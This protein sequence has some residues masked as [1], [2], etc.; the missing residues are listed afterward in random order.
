MKVPKSWR[1]M[2]FL[3]WIKTTE[4]EECMDCCNAVDALAPFAE[5]R[6]G[7]SGRTIDDCCECGGAG[8]LKPK[9]GGFEPLSDLEIADLVDEYH[10]AIERGNAI[11]ER[12]CAENLIPSLRAT[13]ARRH[14]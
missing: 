8:V 10:R 1:P 12:L 13:G 6:D 2:T 7:Y 14:I 5:R 11:F 3:E 9:E 4:Y